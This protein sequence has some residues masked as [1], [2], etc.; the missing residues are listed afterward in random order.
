MTTDELTA[1]IV[2]LQRLSA[3]S[4]ATADA[5]CAFS[6]DGLRVLAKCLADIADRLAPLL[7]NPVVY[8]PTPED[9]ILTAVHDVATR[10]DTILDDSLKALKVDT[11][12]AANWGRKR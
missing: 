8:A 7:D 3:R 9:I 5:N 11:L 12:P 10:L 4:L 1:I 6:G 2:K